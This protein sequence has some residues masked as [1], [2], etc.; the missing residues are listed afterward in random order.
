MEHLKK[1]PCQISAIKFPGNSTSI[2]LHS[3]RNY[4]RTAMKHTIRLRLVLTLKFGNVNLR[5]CKIERKEMKTIN[6]A[7][8]VQEIA[9]CKGQTKQVKY[10][11]ADEI[12][13]C[14]NC[15]CSTEGLTHFNWL[16]TVCSSLTCF[17]THMFLWITCSCFKL[18]KYIFW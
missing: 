18:L 16:I 7:I 6:K 10:E 8:S 1:L 3:R 9:R 15:Y 17:K 14:E 11:S 13:C 2:N 4:K 12:G 5:Q